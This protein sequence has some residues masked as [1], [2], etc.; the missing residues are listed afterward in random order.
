MQLVVDPVSWGTIP[1]DERRKHTVKPYIKEVE[2]I[3]LVDVLK[4]IDREK[5]VYKTN[6][7]REWLS[8]MVGV[9]LGCTMALLICA[10]WLI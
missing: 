8:M 7:K 1:I 4:Y 2:V 5:I 9:I 6:R 3:K 10:K